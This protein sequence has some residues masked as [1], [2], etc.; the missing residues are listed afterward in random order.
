MILPVG[1]AHKF[2]RLLIAHNFFRRR[3]KLQPTP[4]AGGDGSQMYQRCGQVADFN[5]GMRSPPAPDA[6]QKIAMMRQTVQCTVHFFAKLVL[7]PKQ[8]PAAALA[9]V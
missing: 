8:L 3:I 5:I 2:C 4:D 9:R 7:R 6:L 1:A